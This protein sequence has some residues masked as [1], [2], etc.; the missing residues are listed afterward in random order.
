MMRGG[1]GE[2]DITMT[3]AFPSPRSCTGS[4]AHGVAHTARISASGQDAALTVNSDSADT[5]SFP[6]PV[7]PRHHCVALV[8]Q[9]TSYSGGQTLFHAQLVRVIGVRLERTWIA[10]GGKAWRLNGRLRPDAQDGGG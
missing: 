10:L 2:K 3:R 7:R 4:P 5:A 8:G 6:G 9:L 1:E